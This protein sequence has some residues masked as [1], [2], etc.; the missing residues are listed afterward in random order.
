MNSNLNHT[1]YIYLM[2]MQKFAYGY[3]PHIHSSGHLPIAGLQTFQNN[4][5]MY[6]YAWSFFHVRSYLVTHSTYLLSFNCM[7]AVLKLHCWRCY[8]PDLSSYIPILAHSLLPWA[9]SSSSLSFYVHS[10]E[11]DPI[12]TDQPHPP[13]LNMSAMLCLFFLLFTFYIGPIF[14]YLSFN[15]N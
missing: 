6:V 13:L 3:V 12:L 2:F 4:I 11:E 5:Y 15:Y 14:K 7:N 1:V 9:L 8:S 10:Y